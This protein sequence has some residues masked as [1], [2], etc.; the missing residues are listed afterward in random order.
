MNRRNFLRILA[1]TAASPIIAPAVTY[2]LPPVGGWPILETAIGQQPPYRGLV[3]LISNPSGPSWVRD[4]FLVPG[5][6]QELW[7]LQYWQVKPPYISDEYLGISRAPL[8]LQKRL[9]KAC[10]LIEKYMERS[11]G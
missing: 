10:D 6:P 7:G 9:N 2:F 5:L 4:Q 1:G 11:N 3:R 8:P